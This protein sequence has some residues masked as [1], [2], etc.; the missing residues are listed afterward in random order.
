MVTASYSTSPT[1][2][3]STH[4][5]FTWRPYHSLQQIRASSKGFITVACRKL[6]AAWTRCGL[7]SWWSSKAI[8]VPFSLSHFRLMDPKSFPGQRTRPL[9]PLRGHNNRIQF[10]AFSP[11]G[12]KII[13]GS[14]LDSNIRVWDA[15]TGIMLPHPQITADDSAMPAINK[16]M[17]RQWL[18]NINTGR[19]MGALP[20]DS[21]FD[22]GRVHGST[23]FGWTA[24]YKLVII[25]FP[26]Q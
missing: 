11:D 19:Y 25:H 7:Q 3:M 16:P 9:P 12:S 22:C 13:S 1:R 10:I 2:S 6:F 14:H 8:V 4:C 17:I 26:D 18:T 20:V 5:W 24:G 15:N 21:Y 23:Y